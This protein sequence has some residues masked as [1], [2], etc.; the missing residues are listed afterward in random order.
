MT[1]VVLD[2]VFNLACSGGKQI[3]GS[4][5]HSLT[6]ITL[7]SIE[8]TLDVMKPQPPDE[9]DELG[10]IQMVVLL[11]HTQFVFIAETNES[12]TCDLQPY[13]VIMAS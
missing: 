8:P 12:P 4:L 1:R 7:L 10:W 5:V 11:N 6:I 3:N 13:N 2:A 9:S